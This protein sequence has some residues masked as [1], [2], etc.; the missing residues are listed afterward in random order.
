M[1]AAPEAELLQDETAQLRAAAA[2][3]H[4]Q[5]PRIRSQTA[6]KKQ[7]RT[8]QKFWK[9]PIASQHRSRSNLKNLQ[10]QSVPV[11]RK[12]RK[13]GKFW[14]P[15]IRPQN[16]RTTPAGWK[17]KNP[18]LRF[19]EAEQTA[20][21][22][23]TEEEEYLEAESEGAP[24]SAESGAGYCGSIL[25]GRI[26]GRGHTEQPNGLTAYDGV[27]HG[28]ENATALVPIIIKDGA[29][30]Y[31]GFWKDDRKD[32]VGVSFRNSDHALHVAPWEEGRPGKFASL[33]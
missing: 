12:L 11:S 27:L 24:L 18:P 31:A 14:T 7:S 22:P 15:P 10:N 5:S 1:A 30:C 26:S 29:L 4:S 6:Q 3:E 20:A 9:P 33:F 25:D 2:R 8:L 32:G 13:T 28:P 21:V 16:Q 23:V 19:K 17:A